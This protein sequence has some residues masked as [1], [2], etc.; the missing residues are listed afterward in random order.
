MKIYFKNLTIP[1]KAAKRIAKDLI[2]TNA[3]PKSVKLSVA[4]EM[5]SKMLGYNSWYQLVKETKE[6]GHQES[7]LDE[8]C[9]FGIQKERLA[10]QAEQLCLNYPMDSSDMIE[11]AVR[12]RV[13]GKN[14]LSDSL[15]MS[16]NYYNRLR[17]GYEQPYSKEKTWRFYPS[18]RSSD[19]FMKELAEH[20]DLWERCEI[21]LDDYF[22]RLLNEFLRIPE[23]VYVIREILRLSE[24]M[25]FVVAITL[26]DSFGKVIVESFPG[27]LPESGDLGLNW[28]EEENR[29]LV[30]SVYWLA[31]SY[32]RSG[33]FES[34]KRWFEFTSRACKH[35]K[36]CCDQYLEDMHTF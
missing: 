23:S 16:E 26:L 5:A 1:K 15:A 29:P 17:M 18:V 20:S 35:F 6:G 13:S 12:L 10:F 9:D 24:E 28:F 2:C 3:K 21:N 32:Y 22:N 7:L 30:Q 19:H 31:L 33:Y 14:P 11:I 8:D 34:A 25:E 36:D 4:Q 27:D